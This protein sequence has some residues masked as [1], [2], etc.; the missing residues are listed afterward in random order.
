MFKLRVIFLSLSSVSN[1]D[2]TDNMSTAYDEKGLK[3][4]G[5]DKG[6]YD[7]ETVPVYDSA[8]PVEFEEKKDLR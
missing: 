8:G 4:H 3:Q 7:V 2:D 1:L 5:E 6:V